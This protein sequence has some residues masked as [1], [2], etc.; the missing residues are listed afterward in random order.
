MYINVHLIL[1]LFLQFLCTSQ[2]IFRDLK[3]NYR[4]DVWERNGP[5]VITRLLQT[6]CSTN[7][8]PEM[9]ASTCLGAYNFMYL[10]Y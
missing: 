6:I 5:G 10:T 7:Y 2:I 8:L 4:G 1:K 3:D 9:S